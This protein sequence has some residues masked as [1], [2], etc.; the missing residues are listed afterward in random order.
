MSACKAPQ[1]T[2][3][4]VA[5]DDDRLP[6]TQE[7]ILQDQGRA[8]IEAA[9]AR[10]AELGEPVVIR[11]LITPVTAAWLLGDNHDNR[12]LSEPTVIKYA[13]D[14]VA[15]R[16][17]ENGDGFAISKCG[18]LNN[19]QHRNEA[20]LK[21]GVSF[22]TNVTV[23]LERDA[24][25]TNDIGLARTLSSLLAMDGVENHT[26]IGPMSKIIIGWETTNTAAKRPTRQNSIGRV[27]ERISGDERMAEAAAFVRSLKVPKGFL[28]KPQVGFFHYV[29]NDHAP[30]QAEDFL[31]GLVTGEED[32]R[33]LITDDPRRLMRERLIREHKELKLA[34]RVELVFKAWNAWR[35]GR[36]VRQ[37]K[38]FGVLPDL[39]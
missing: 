1:K 11:T 12:N 33:G 14:L 39:V 28:S 8:D 35:E 15:G 5:N 27:R 2:A 32:G 30:E 20:C 25:A 16:W 9:M 29:L 4:V 17:K 37:Y 24:R 36:V 23:G 13:D 19:G 3:Q 38:I 6:P 22:Y 26:I 18:G 34:D 21:S 31:R 7:M 10:S